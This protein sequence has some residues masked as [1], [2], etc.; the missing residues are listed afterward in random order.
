MRRISKTITSWIDENF[1]E[2]AL[3]VRQNDAW[4]K[5]YPKSGSV[6]HLDLRCHEDCIQASIFSGL[7]GGY[8]D[9]KEWYYHDEELFN[10][11]GEHVTKFLSKYRTDRSKYASTFKRIAKKVGKEVFPEDL[12]KQ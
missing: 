6:T 8:K 12:R 9:S 2:T 11:I 3:V 7:S 1:S 4:L 10:R 5:I